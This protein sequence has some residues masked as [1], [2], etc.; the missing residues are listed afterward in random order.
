[1]YTK[2]PGA[3]KEEGGQR[4]GKEKKGKRRE[5]KRDREA[6]LKKNPCNYEDPSETGTAFGAGWLSGIPPF[7]KRDE[8][9]ACEL[10]DEEEEG[11]AEGKMESGD[12]VRRPPPAAAVAAAP[13]A[14]TPLL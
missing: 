4:K 11:G 7:C 10:I 1:M 5:E 9:L 12:A 2:E 3:R 14:G 8:G 13:E 6:I